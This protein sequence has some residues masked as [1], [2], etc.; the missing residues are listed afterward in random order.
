M[1]R[2]DREVEKT[3]VR[4]STGPL[5]HVQSQAPDA[6]AVASS[7]RAQYGGSNPGSNPGTTFN[8]LHLLP[9]SCPEILPSYANFYASLLRT[10]IERGSLIY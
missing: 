7:P 6:I 2:S 1:S 8:E 5:R 10:S 4:A 3:R 9:R